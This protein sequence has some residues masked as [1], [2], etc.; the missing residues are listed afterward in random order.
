LLF[1]LHVFYFSLFISCMW[2]TFVVVLCER[3]WLRALRLPAKLH[4]QLWS[5]FKLPCSFRHPFD[6]LAIKVCTYQRWISFLS[7]YHLLASCSKLSTNTSSFHETDKHGN[8]SMTKKNT[9]T[10]LRSSAAVQKQRKLMQDTESCMFSRQHSTF[11]LIYIN[12]LSETILLVIK[13]VLILLAC[14]NYSLVYREV[15]QSTSSHSLARKHAD[16]CFLIR[17]KSMVGRWKSADESTPRVP[18]STSSTRK[19]G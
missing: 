12:M 16:A 7:V 18:C 1:V 4:L 5:A 17:L 8:R 15:L 10:C 19:V 3:R 2:C 14:L 6:F 13:N 11:R 9:K